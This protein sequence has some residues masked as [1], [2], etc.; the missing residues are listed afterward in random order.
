VAAKPTIEIF[1]GTGYTELGAALA[2]SVENCGETDAEMAFEQAGPYAVL[3]AGSARR[4]EFVGDRYE[5]K[6]YVRFVTSAEVQ[7]Q[8]VSVVKITHNC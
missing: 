2:F 7:S 3:P 6:L 1:T 8:A 4:F 5:G